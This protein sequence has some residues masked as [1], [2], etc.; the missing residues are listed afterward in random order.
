MKIVRND[1]L[2]D[3]KLFIKL[4]KDVVNKIISYWYPK[5]KNII[6]I[7]KYYYILF[8]PLIIYHKILRELELNKKCITNIPSLLG[9]KDGL[10][11]NCNQ[12][13]K[14]GSVFCS[15]C[16]HLYYSNFS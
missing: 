14:E 4:P 13:R 3:S 2:L 9:K 10:K 11:L 1:S 7:T 16:G 15:I 6:L 5:K 12:N 8:Q